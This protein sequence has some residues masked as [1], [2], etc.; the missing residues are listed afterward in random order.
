MADDPL[1]T[2]QGRCLCGACTFEL[3]GPPNWVGHCHCQSC[4]RATASP[5]TTWI[6]QENGSWRFTGTAPVVYQS[7][8]GATRGFCG[9]CGSPMFYQSERYP[10]E[11][12]F[13][14]ALLDHPE[15]V[16]P[17][18]HFHADEKLPWVHLSG[19]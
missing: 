11:R 8:P 1:P 18:K 7:S 3:T 15:R 16:E 4:R 9:N 19:V 10:N 2:L 12:H 5:F 17:T 13:Y 14:A 6:G